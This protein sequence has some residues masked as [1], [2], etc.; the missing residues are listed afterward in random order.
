[1]RAATKMRLFGAVL[2]VG[3]VFFASTELLPLVKVP[4]G[5]TSAGP[6]TP[7]GSVPY[8]ISGYRIPPVDAG[9]Y[10]N[11]TVAGVSPSPVLVVLEPGNGVSTGPPVYSATVA[12]ALGVGVKSPS[13]QAY[14]LVI[15]SVNRTTYVLRVD[16]YWSPFF[17]LAGYTAEAVLV[18]LVGLGGFYYYRAIRQRE[19]LEAAVMAERRGASAPPQP[20]S[21]G[22]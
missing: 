11:I 17:D 12:R 4:Q 6:P 5:F 19:E 2:V 13:D 10:I 22:H 15:S 1:M 7:Y 14:T 20:Q 3:V 18:V 8:A 21:A 16:S 9:V